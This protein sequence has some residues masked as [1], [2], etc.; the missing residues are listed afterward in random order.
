M[1]VIVNYA[2]MDQKGNDV[3]VQS[4][5]LDAKP[6]ICP[7]CHVRMSP[8]E[9]GQQG[10]FVSEAWLDIA[11]RCANRECSHIFVARYLRDHGRPGQTPAYNF[12]G[13]YPVTPVERTFAPEITNLSPN[14]VSIFTQAEAAEQAGLVEVAGP[15]FRKAFEF[16]I[17]DFAITKVPADA[18]KIKAQQLVPVVTTYLDGDKLPIVSQRAAWLGNDETHYHRRWV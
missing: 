8:H 4:K 7:V 14:F 6:N 2:G 11:F 10:G 13:A 12:E 15:G 9:T 16:L 1:P 17:K 5:T 3:A 18:E